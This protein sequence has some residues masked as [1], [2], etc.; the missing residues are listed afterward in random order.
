VSA[1]IGVIKS[2][3]EKTPPE[4][5]SDVIDRGIVMIGGGAMLRK[6]DELISRE[7]G[8][9]AYVADAPMAC[10]AMGAGTALAHYEAMRRVVPGL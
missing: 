9:P 4:L 3:L 8:V 5:S 10:V 6:M 2:V 1:V 7:T